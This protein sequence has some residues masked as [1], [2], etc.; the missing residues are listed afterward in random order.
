MTVL[1]R[2]EPLADATVVHWRVTT[3]S[4]PLVSGRFEAAKA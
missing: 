4:A 3:L 1:G 2:G